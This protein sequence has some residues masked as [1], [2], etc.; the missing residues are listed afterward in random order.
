MLKT[1]LNTF[2]CNLISSHVCSYD[3]NDKQLFRVSL[4]FKNCTKVYIN[5]V[6]VPKQSVYLVS[7]HKNTDSIKVKLQGLFSNQT[8]FL[9]VKAASIEVNFSLF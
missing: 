9:Q 8:I 1:I 7:T 4:Y 3:G 6:L 2:K 5:D